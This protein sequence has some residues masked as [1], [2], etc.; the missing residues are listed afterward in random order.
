V[1]VL[2]QKVQVQQ[3]WST[4]VGPLLSSFSPSSLE[5]L[6]MPLPAMLT[7]LQEVNK[8]SGS[9]DPRTSLNYSAI[10]QVIYHSACHLTPPSQHSICKEPA[11]LLD[12]GGHGQVE[13]ASENLIWALLFNP[14]RLWLWRNLADFYQK[15]TDG[16]LCEAASRIRT[17][18]CVL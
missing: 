13:E 6:N 2:C 7:H 10:Y 5:M 16:L 15:V 4:V 14:R 12:I 9:S 17:K 1:S 3:L 11:A 8:A 18:V